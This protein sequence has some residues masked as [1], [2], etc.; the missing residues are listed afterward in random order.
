MYFGL[1]NW[2]TTGGFSG[3]LRDKIKKLKY[4]Q[5]QNWFPQSTCAYYRCMNAGYMRFYILIMGIRFK[6]PVICIISHC[7]GLFDVIF[8]GFFRLCILMTGSV[9]NIILT[10]KDIF[11]WYQSHDRCVWDLFLK[12][13]SFRHW[14][15]IEWICFL[16]FL[17]VTDGGENSIC[18]YNWKVLCKK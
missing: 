14:V 11:L 9:A 18:P 4:Q 16:K 7:S 15:F 6:S 13:K 3:N 12:Q 17:I 1:Y 10:Y 8:R 2:G 5:V